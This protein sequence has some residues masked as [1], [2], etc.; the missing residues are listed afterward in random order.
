MARVLLDRDAVEAAVLGGAV[1]GGGGGGALALGRR[2]GLLAVELGAPQ[3]VDLDDLGPDAVLATVSAVGSPAATTAY[4]LPVH[5]VRAVE[6][7]MKY[8]ETSV[9]GLITNECGALASVNGWLQAAALGLPVVDAPCNGRAHPTG[10]MG[11]MGLHQ[12]A[13]YMSTQAA[14]GGDPTAG[15]YVEAF[16]R[17]NLARTAPLVLQASVQA[18]GMV[19]VARNPVS[20][21]YARDHAAP[22]AIRQSIAL[23]RAMLERQAVGP[24][25]MIEAVCEVL[26]GDLAIRGVV[27]D[28]RLET[29]GGL[30]VGAVRV[31]GGDDSR[32]QVAELGFWNEY[33]SLDLLEADSDVVRRAATFPDLLATM[34]ISSGLPLG[35]AEV[36]VGQEVAVVQVDRRHLILGA[37]MRDPALLHS[38]E[39]ATG[40]EIVAGV[41]S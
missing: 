14:V 2:N 21:E 19:A 6:L 39:E 40:R 27:A 26:H 15:R 35:S 9:H 28:V 5:Y 7:L 12:V 31:E 25:A 13:G 16:V 41:G 30:D 20:V 4:A 8:G 37:G 34:D 24:I 1:L 17:G 18:G 22:G 29:V 32:R 11:S 33:V 10:L 38:I 36:R 23:G 3:L